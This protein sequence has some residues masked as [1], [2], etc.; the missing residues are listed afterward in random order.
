M[1]TLIF[2]V[3]SV[4]M[5]NTLWDSDMDSNGFLSQSDPKASIFAA[6]LGGPPLHH[7]HAPHP[8]DPG[9]LIPFNTRMTQMII[10]C[11]FCNF[12]FDFLSHSESWVFF[13]AELPE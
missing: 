8:P 2:G 10:L 4:A 12:C 1:C 6:T 5:C 13:V 7:R 9:F 11:A 3:S